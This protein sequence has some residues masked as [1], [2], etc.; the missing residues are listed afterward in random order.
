MIV[1]QKQKHRRTITNHANVLNFVQP[2]RFTYDNYV[3]SFSAKYLIQRLHV[4]FT[5]IYKY[6]FVAKLAN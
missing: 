2:S 6:F 1:N 4:E 5:K 3:V